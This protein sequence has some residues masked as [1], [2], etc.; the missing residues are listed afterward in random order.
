MKKRKLYKKRP[1]YYVTAVQLDLDFDGIEYR[2]WGG[3]QECKPGDW[4]VNNNGDTYTVDKEYFRDFYQRVSPGV[5]NKIGEI[6][7]E[8]AEEIG[9]IGAKEGSTDFN[10]GDYLVFDRP[11]GGE[12]YAIN[13]LIFKRMY[14][15][16]DPKLDLSI[17]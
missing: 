17:E 3:K 9:S 12:G 14:E 6:W 5:F 7:V 2:K 16:I 4:L 1:K 15:E 10:A 11:E 13:K 8:V